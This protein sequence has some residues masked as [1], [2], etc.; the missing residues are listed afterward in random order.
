MCKEKQ[1]RVVKVTKRN[2]DICWMV[3]RLF[4]SWITGRAHWKTY[5]S[6][7]EGSTWTRHLNWGTEYESEKEATDRVNFLIHRDNAVVTDIKV[8]SAVRTD[9][10]GNVY[11][12]YDANEKK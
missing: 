5:A 3:Q 1:Y 8:I 4:R 10:S 12:T 7:W 11:L 2:G 9:C 6:S